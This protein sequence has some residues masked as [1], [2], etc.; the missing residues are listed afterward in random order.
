MKQRVEKANDTP[1]IRMSEGTAST[2]SFVGVRR[3]SGEYEAARRE[4]REASRRSKF[5]PHW[6]GDHRGRAK[7]KN[8]SKMGWKCFG[9]ECGG[10]GFFFSSFSFQN[11]IPFDGEGD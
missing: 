11:L 4:Q 2:P 1:G 6:N 9:L 3:T 10:G 5:G 8:T 7:K